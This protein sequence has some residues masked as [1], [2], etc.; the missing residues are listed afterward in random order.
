MFDVPRSDYQD[1]LQ[2]NK[3]MIILK[4]KVVGRTGKV[5]DAKA[6]SMSLKAGFLMT[7][8]S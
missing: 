4:G 2:E 8:L 5:I 1:E 7:H 6:L 3:I